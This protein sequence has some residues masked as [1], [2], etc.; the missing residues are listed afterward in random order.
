LRRPPAEALLDAAAIR[1]P[2]TLRV[3]LPGERFQ[4][5]NAPGRCLLSDFFAS[6]KVHVTLRSV[7]PVLADGAGPVW[8]LGLGIAHRARVTPGTED[9]VRLHADPLN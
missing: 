1:P 4:P 2:L 8:V 6:R 3:A 7:W 9:V 5:L